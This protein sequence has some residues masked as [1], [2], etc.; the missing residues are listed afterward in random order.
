MEFSGRQIAR[1][2]YE[3]NGRDPL[4]VIMEVWQTRAGAIVGMRSAAPCEREG[5]EVVEV[6]V[7]EPQEDAVA[8]RFQIMDLFNWHDRAR[9]NAAA[10]FAAVA[11]D[12][13]EYARVFG[14]E[15]EGRHAQS[16]GNL[17]CQL[18]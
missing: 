18:E 1:D 9:W 12:V 8:M 6:A 7:A 14:G 10:E 11:E 2:E 5:I 4:N 13:E 15:E 3:T 17:L 16:P